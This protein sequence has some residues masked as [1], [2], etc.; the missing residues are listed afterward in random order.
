MEVMKRHTNNF[1][2][3][4]KFEEKIIRIPYN[5]GEVLVRFQINDRVLF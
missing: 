3:L 5:Y 1:N 4:Y 2:L